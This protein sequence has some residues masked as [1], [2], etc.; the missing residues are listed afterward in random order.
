MRPG[1]LDRI[2]YVSLPDNLTRKEIFELKVKKMPCSADIDLDKLVER[3]EKYS[4]AEITA[5][6]NEAAFK[7]LERDINSTHVT[8]FDFESALKLVPPRTSD[9][10]IKYFDNFSLNSDLHEI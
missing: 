1:R 4:G 10:T 2:V 7:A 8:M 3:T 5:V 9:E 6:C